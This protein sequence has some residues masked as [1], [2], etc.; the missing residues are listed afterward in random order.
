MTSDEL[1]TEVVAICEAHEKLCKYI[2][3]N[4]ATPATPHSDK[5]AL[6]K[7]GDRAANL[8]AKV[9]N[10]SGDTEIVVLDGI[11]ELLG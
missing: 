2:V 10:L 11:R 6:L 4:I 8:A 7:S 9:N 3:E 1:K 5:E